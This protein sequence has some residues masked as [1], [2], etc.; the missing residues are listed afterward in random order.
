MTR[1]FGRSAASARGYICLAGPAEPFR[2][3]S[4]PPMRRIAVG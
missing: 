4:A 2:G 1:R 3:P